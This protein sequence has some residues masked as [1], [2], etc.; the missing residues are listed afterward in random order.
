M[1]S[2]LDFDSTNGFRKFILGK[3]LTTP[4]GPQTFNSDSYS[5]QK[6]SDMSNVDAGTVEDTREGE[7]VR[8]QTSNT[9][10]PIE[11]FVKEDL[12]TIPRQA[13][14]SL[15]PYFETEQYHSFISIATG[16]D[17]TNESNLMK[18]A[19]WN[20]KDNP[21]GPIKARI[22]QNLYTTTAGKVRLLDA[23][24]GNTTTAINIVTGREPIIET[25][26]S[27]TVAATL[28]GK[29]ID[30]LQTVAGVEFPFTEIPGDDLSKP[31]KLELMRVRL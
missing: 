13:N 16:N 24:Q 23:L 14:L 6:T 21:V 5:I 7:L 25:N 29:A 2:Y 18:F 30:F 1:P 17:F 22:A 11:Y 8:A 26:D 12:R 20:I 27:I 28:P 3:T 15:Y 9:F 4:N 19:A 31:K 10:K